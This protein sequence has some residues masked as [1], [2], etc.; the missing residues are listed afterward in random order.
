MD[1]IGLHIYITNVHSFLVCD[2]IGAGSEVQRPMVDKTIINSTH[3][4]ISW[5][6]P[7]EDVDGFKLS[8]CGYGGDCVNK[9]FCNKTWHIIE[10]MGIAFVKIYALRYSCGD[11]VEESPETIITI[12][13]LFIPHSHIPRLY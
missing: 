5:I 8:L 4:N 1:S 9:T 2:T 12:G 10:T 13:K 6:K 7:S 3:V 11:I